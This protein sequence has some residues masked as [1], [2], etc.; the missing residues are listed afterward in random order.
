MTKLSK[1]AENQIKDAIAALDKGIAFIMSDKTRVVRLT[2]VT[3][4]PDSTWTNSEGLKGI[5]ITR[6][7][8]SDLCFIQNAR[9]ALKRMITPIEIETA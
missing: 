8:G 3:C 6:E 7:I 4:G 2:N 5:A 9:E 1:K